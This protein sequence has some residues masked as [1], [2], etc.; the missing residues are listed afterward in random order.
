VAASR[1]PHA[2]PRALPSLCSTRRP[3]HARVARTSAYHL[4]SNFPLG[5]QLPD[6]EY[7]HLHYTAQPSFCARL[8][9]VPVA[10]PAARNRSPEPAPMRAATLRTPRQAEIPGPTACARLLPS[11]R[12][13]SYALPDRCWPARVLPRPSCSVALAPGD[14]PSRAPPAR[15]C[16]RTARV[17]QHLPRPTLAEPPRSRAALAPRGAACAGARSCLGRP[18]PEPRPPGPRALPHARRP[19]SA[20]AARAWAARSRASACPAR[21]SAAAASSRVS[22]SRR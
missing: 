14:R 13:P 8:A 10:P 1:T 2:R 18:P 6:V 3:R 19:G 17:R 5:L 7:G 22:S 12:P 16:T 21:I 4:S 9:S 15:A 11:C 20:A